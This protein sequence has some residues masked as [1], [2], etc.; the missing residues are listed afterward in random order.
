MWLRRIV[1][2]IYRGYGWMTM[3]SLITQ[4]NVYIQVFIPQKSNT[5]AHTHTHT[6]T[7]LNDSIPYTF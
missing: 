6:L 4:Y 3:I 2:R 7:T 1:L 5:Q